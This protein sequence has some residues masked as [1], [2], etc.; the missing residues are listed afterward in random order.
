MKK[1]SFIFVSLIL[2]SLTGC[3]ITSFS[4]SSSTSSN[5]DTSSTSGSS[6]SSNSKQSS[7]SSS[8]NSDGSFS[9]KIASMNDL[10]GAIEENGQ[11]S[12]LSKIST[13]LKN[14]YS[15]NDVLLANGDM[16]QG[17]GES[18]LNKG[19][20]ITEWM[21]LVGFDAMG[22]GN[23]DFD[24]GQE[25]IKANKE[26]ANFPFLDCNVYHYENGAVTTHADELGDTS[27]ILNVG[28]YKVGVVGGIGRGQYTSITAT[29]VDGLE[30]K[31]VVDSFQNESDKLR[32]AGCNVVVAEVHD[33]SK[34]GTLLSLAS[35][36]SKTNK[37]YFDAVFCGHAHSRDQQTSNGV[38]FVMGFASGED[39]SEVTVTI[40]KDGAV[41]V[42][43]ST[44]NS[45]YP[46]SLTTDSDTET[47]LN[48]YRTTQDPVLDTKVGNNG[49]GISC[50]GASRTQLGNLYSKAMYEA[51][52][53]VDSSVVLAINNGARNYLDS[54]A[55][56]F[57]GIYRSFPFDNNVVIITV[58]GSDLYEE[59]VR[60]SN[61]IYNPTKLSTPSSSSTYRI[62]IIDYMALHQS[63]T[64]TL[65]Y[66]PS[67]SNQTILTDDK[68]LPRNLVRDYLDTQTS[69]YPSAY[70]GDLYQYA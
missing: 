24:W 63:A 64:H 2:T 12:G 70:S 61:C 51:A 69:F 43:S 68:Y 15:S 41:S 16:W 31:E 37:P 62:A 60:Y 26:V 21:N 46:S 5:E 66:F 65:N 45:I 33:T 38:P 67:K 7:S 50:S 57:R 10:H 54:G 23:H 48:K 18:N 20:L 53:K 56:T 27:T 36:S 17:N 19:K 40:T 55:L 9:F 8:S 28:S 32:E 47:L 6:S 34:N 42:S 58:S 25:A 4:S 11:E 49:V 39:I 59:T 52:K 13:Y 30:F 1:V 29:Q 44:I 14:N 22:L 3:T 35:N